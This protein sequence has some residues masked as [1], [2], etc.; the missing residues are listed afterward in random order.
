MNP[1]APGHCLYLFGLQ[2]LLEDIGILDVLIVLP[3]IVRRLEILR[4]PLV[5]A[6]PIEREGEVVMR[7]G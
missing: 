7:F 3:E 4:G 5:V 1:L 2:V 6:G